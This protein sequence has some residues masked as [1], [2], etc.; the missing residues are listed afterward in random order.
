MIALNYI[1]ILFMKIKIHII[2]ILL[3]LISCK[4]NNRFEN[5]NI[6]PTLNIDINEFEKKI[7]NQL[8]NVFV[9]IEIIGLETTQNSLIQNI[10]KLKILG[11]NIYILDTHGAKSLLVFTIDG[12][13][14][15]KI[16][17]AGNGP[18]EFM[19]PIDFDVSSTEVRILSNKK[20]LVFDLYGKFI[21][22]FSLDFSAHYFSRI[23]ADFDAFYGAYNEDKII[24]ANKKGRK[25]FSF[26][27][28]SPRNR[29]VT[30]WSIQKVDTVT[31][32][33]IPLCDTIFQVNKD[34]ISPY[35]VIDF[36]IG[37]FKYENFNNLPEENKMDA[38]NYVLSSKRF[39]L[40]Q[41]YSET[42]DY[43]LLSFVYNKQPIFSLHSKNLNSSLFYNVMD[44]HDDIWYSQIYGLPVCILDDNIV[45]FIQN[46]PVLAIEAYKK[47]KEKSFKEELTKNEKEILESLGIICKKLD[48]LSNPIIFIAKINDAKFKRN[49]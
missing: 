16:G 4:N 44:C 29:L 12:R 31:I 26:F 23:S 24:V 40:K 17:H 46:Y 47:L 25:K 1:N 11:Q 20:I 6:V 43:K 13:F 39:V 18:G 3:F 41:F 22:E 35:C 42:Q 32:F 2:W 37:S 33:N 21:R 5:I 36:G 45:V 30:P 7:V 9:P 14:K 49:I 27:E 19:I 15:Y 48:E 38:V 10:D 28:Y 34:I 8:S